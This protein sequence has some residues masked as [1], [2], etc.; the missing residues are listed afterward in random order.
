MRD[1]GLQP[2]RT[3]LAWS[4]TGLLALL[5]AAL[6]IRIGLTV[7]AVAHLVV[8]LLLAALALALLHR[9]HMRSRYAVRDDVVTRS[10][11]RLLFAT[12]ATV[13][14]ASAIQATTIIV[15]LLR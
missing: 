1:S 15:R 7:V 5:T 2:E 13:V 14:A 10:S 12:S 9:G 4:R 8:A 6:T 3:G 11:Q